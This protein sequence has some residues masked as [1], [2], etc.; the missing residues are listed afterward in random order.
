[1]QDANFTTTYDGGLRWMNVSTGDFTKAYRIYNG[2]RASG[3]VFGKAAGI[4]DVAVL[5][6]EAPIELGNRVWLDVNNN[7]RQ[8]ASEAGHAGITVNLLNGKGDLLNST[9]T[10]AGGA[11]YFTATNAAGAGRPGTQPRE[12]QQRHEQRR[13][14][15]C[16]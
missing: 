16:Q 3:N 1:V 8:D 6:D 9:V 4:G 15:R 11:Y 14:Q 5:C 7:G 10:A 2:E 13:H 12:L